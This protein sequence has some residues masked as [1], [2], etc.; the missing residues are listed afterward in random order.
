MKRLTLAL[1]VMTAALLAMGS[2][3][4]AQISSSSSSSWSQSYSSSWSSS[5][6][7]GPGGYYNNRNFKEESHGTSSNSS[8][9]N[10]PFGGRTTGS[11]RQWGS[12]RT[13]HS[14][15]GWT[16]YGGSYNNQGGSFDS[17]NRGRNFNNQWRW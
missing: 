3:A 13:G 4:Q 8:T 12:R 5:Q 11:T 16:P 15:S 17:Y 2:E 9:I 6:G 14:S 1:A 10:T 7:F